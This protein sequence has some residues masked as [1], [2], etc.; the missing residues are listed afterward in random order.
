[1]RSKLF[2]PGSRPELFEKAWTSAADAISFDLEDAVAAD[3]KAEARG[4][5][6]T[7]LDNHVGDTRIAI[8]RV[9]PWGEDLFEDDL[10]AVVRPGLDIVN[11]PKIESTEPILATARI[12]DQLEREHGIDRRI[13]ILANIETPRGLRLAAEIALAHERVIGLQ[14]GFG[15]LFEPLAIERNA[16]ALLPVRLAVRF[17]AAEAGIDVYDGAFVAVSDDDAYRADAEAARALGLAGKSCVHPSQIAI[18]NAVFFPR[19]AEIENARRIIDKA[20]EMLARG[21]GAFTVDGVMAD[22]PFIDRARA[23]LKI[24]QSAGQHV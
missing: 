7:S 13:G 12:L 3:R 14:L 19:A 9:N 16:A 6:A 2:V 15:D 18:A 22:G 4:Y 17:A 20:D 21:V 23:V 8:V 5:V 11:L 10:A 1:M 24:A